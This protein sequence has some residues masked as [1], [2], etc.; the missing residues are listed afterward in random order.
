MLR[1]H[2]AEEADVELTTRFSL[3]QDVAAVPDVLLG[4]CNWP[5]MTQRLSSRYLVAALLDCSV[6]EVR[7][8][9]SLTSCRNASSDETSERWASSES[10]HA[11][12]AERGDGELAGDAHNTAERDTATAAART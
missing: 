2:E 6:D 3:V 1:L 8:S 10:H 9:R 7:S 11:H 5:E 4:W 12:L